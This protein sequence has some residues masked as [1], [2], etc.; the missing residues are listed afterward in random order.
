MFYTKKVFPHISLI[1]IP[2]FLSIV[3]YLQSLYS[4]FQQ[5]EWLA[6]SRHILLEGADKKVFLEDVFLTAGVHYTP[7]TVLSI[8]L[9]FSFLGLNYVGYALV[10]IL[11]HVIVVILVFYLARILLQNNFLALFVSALFGISAAG[12]QATSWVVADI[13][14]HGATILGLLTLILF[15]EFLRSQKIIWF[16]ISLITLIISFLFK[17]ITVGLFVILPLT[18]FFFA[19]NPLRKKNKFPLLIFGVGI[20][21]FAFRAMFLTS[22][23]YISTSKGMSVDLLYKFAFLP[24][25]T[26]SQTLIPP[27]QTIKISYSLAP[28]FKQVATGEKGSTSFDLFVQ[29][30]ILPVLDSMIFLLVAAVLWFLWRRGGFKSIKLP[31]FTFTFVIINSIVYAISPEKSGLISIIDSRNLYFPSIGT[32]IFVVYVA[33]FVVGNDFRK[34]FLLLLP[35]LALNTFWLNREL[36]YLAEIGSLRKNILFYIKGEYPNLSDKTVFYI[37]S[38]TSY[39]GLPAQERILP[40]QSGFGQTLLVWYYNTQHYPR[41]FYENKFLWGITEQGYKEFTNR[42]FGYFRNFEELG[43]T[44]EDKNLPTDSVIAF[45]FNSFDSTT[46]DI[47][48]EVNGRLEGFLAR[49]K[50][51]NNSDYNLTAS[52]NPEEAYL[53]TDG[54]RSTLWN[55]KLPYSESQYL[56]IDIKSLKNIAEIDI[57][58]YNNKDQNEVGYKISLS[59]DKIN[60]LEVFHSARYTPTDSGIVRIFFK[61]Q[62]ARFIRIYQIGY[63]KYA[64]WVI[65]ELKV[66]E[67]IN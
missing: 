7:L 53:A 22:D 62:T 31:L 44:V 26:V 28:L 49:K 56:E 34:I 65:H 15:F 19:K 6:F 36:S 21:Y 5:D 12:F 58:S 2:I 55:S 41:E 45:S 23:S 63:H 37:E 51:I 38:D 43:K 60:W 50:L 35:L 33:S 59:S 42:G 13:A 4:F 29:N 8:N 52:S 10:S 32:F 30:R 9:L 3:F 14:T 64:P 25:K 48:Q 67:A 27:S 66:Y 47:T 18:F 20:I 11:L 17:E 1:F 61:P 16:W 40:F 57:D 24:V 46:R 54:N 39:Y